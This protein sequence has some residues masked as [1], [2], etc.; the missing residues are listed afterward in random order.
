M[1]WKNTKIDKPVIYSIKPLN[2]I[3]ISKNGDIV[4]KRIASSKEK[5]NGPINWPL[6]CKYLSERDCNFSL[7]DDKSIHK[8]FKI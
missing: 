4:W 3:I 1:R 7:I 2:E 6:N 8:G 5:I